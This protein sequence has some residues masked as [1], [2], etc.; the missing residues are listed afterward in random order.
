MLTQ[1][2][3]NRINA[4]LSMSFLYYFTPWSLFPSFMS[5]HIFNPHSF[6]LDFV[7]QWLL[8]SH[9]NGTCRVLLYRISCTK[10]HLP[11]VPPPL[12]L[13]FKLLPEFS[14]VSH[15]FYSVEHENCFSVF[16]L[17]ILRFN[18]TIQLIMTYWK[19]KKTVVI[20]NSDLSVFSQFF[21][22]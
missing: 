18:Y 22:P 7:D 8:L 1:L 17:Y 15:I 4:K 12:S 6:M 13:N 21:K 20:I 9:L 19:R 16:K 5:C 3:F 11:H 10:W 2:I 14:I